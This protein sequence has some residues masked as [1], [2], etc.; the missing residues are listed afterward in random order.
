MILNGSLI[1]YPW[2]S[3]ASHAQPVMLPKSMFEIFKFFLLPDSRGGPWTDARFTVKFAE[4]FGHTW[5]FVVLDL[6]ES[7]WIQEASRSCGNRKTSSRN[8][9]SVL[10]HDDHQQRLPNVP[11]SLSQSSHCEKSCGH[12]HVK[13]PFVIWIDR[14]ELAARAGGWTERTEC[15]H[16]SEFPDLARAGTLPVCQKYALISSTICR[17]GARVTN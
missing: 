17:V 12:G 2:L 3:L 8:P 16:R 14:R 10:H 9:V 1:T 13:Q 5:R 4:L 7:A 15:V 11:D 6:T